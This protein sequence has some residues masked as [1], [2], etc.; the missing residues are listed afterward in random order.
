MVA[1]MPNSWFGTNSEKKRTKKPKD[2][3]IP[4]LIIAFPVV[5]KV[6]D[7]DFA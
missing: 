2:K 3:I 1:K 6:S 5:S 7:T 4:V